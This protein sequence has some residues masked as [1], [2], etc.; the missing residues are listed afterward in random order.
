MLSKLRQILSLIVALSL[1]TIPTSAGDAVKK[2]DAGQTYYVSLSG[3]SD[4]NDGLSE[5]APLATVGKVNSLDLQPGDRVLFKCGDIWRADPLIITQSGSADSPITFGAHPPGCTDL[6]VLSGAQ[7]ISGWTL[8]AGNV[9]AADLS[10]GENAGRFAYGVNQLFRDGVRLTPGRWPNLDAGDGGYSTIDG[11]PASAQITDNELPAGDWS[12]AVAHIKGM[13]WYILNREVTGDAGQTLTLGANADC[14]GGSCAGWGFFVN[15]HLLTLDRD[16]EWFY[17]AATHTV[18]LY[19][20]DSAPADDQVEGSVILRDDDRAWGGV[21]LGEDLGDEIAHVIVEALDIR[22]WYLHGITTPTNLRNYENSTIT[23]RNNVITNLDGIG[24]NLATWVYDAYDGQSGWR[25]G[26]HVTVSDNV[27]DGANH[28]GIN[29]YAKQS[30]ISGNVIR[31][32]ALIA[33]L[34]ASGMGCGPTASG[35]YCTEDGDGIRIKVD[36]AADSGNHNSVTQ[37]VLERIAYNGIDVFGHSNTL[38]HNVIRH[39]CYAKGDCG[40]VRTFG[41]SNLT[42]TSVHDLA[43]NQNIIIEPIGNTDGCLDTYDPL[44]GFGLY[45]D[46]YTRDVAVTGN[47]II[48]AT[49]AGVLFQRS[50]GSITGNTLYNNSAG[51]MYSAQVALGG[52]PT[53]I[54]QHNGNVLYALKENARTLSLS[55]RDRLTA[56]DQNYFFHPYVQRHISSEGSRTLAEWQAYS[57][58]DAGS[59]EAWFTLST[60]DAPR[61]RIFYND[62][63]QTEV[64]DLGYTVYKDLDQNQVAGSLTLPPY[65]SRVLVASGGVAD[66]DLKMAL[67]GAPAVIPGSPLTYTLA[68]TNQGTSTATQVVLKHPIPAAVI[69]S[70][71]DASPSLAGIVVQSSSRYVWEMPDFA[72]GLGGVLTVTAALSEGL[73]TPFTLTL[74]A[75][76]TTPVNETTTDNNSALLLL[77]TWNEVFLPIVEK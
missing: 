6:P 2:S 35:G 75:N 64:I 24:V 29:T 41:N 33:N 27:V 70:T 58:L 67:V 53:T 25:G 57:G 3:G 44:F 69:N 56:S 48:S 66:L 42:D 38:E 36:K 30:T 49:A 16:G 18:Y 14:W 23:L 61:S 68:V 1:V 11:Q 50:T 51:T 59:S 5:G 21:V 40:G 37:N 26:N 52:S 32:I 10:A 15:N 60:G 31:N 63:P 7:P 13:R 47:T 22:Q 19:A 17:D 8:Y 55:E 4:D 12:G 62:T 71:W 46:N 72:P 28:K 74:S 73:G 43:F 20:E 39:A 77:G 76:V 9:Y 45:F 65:S 34:G 54:T